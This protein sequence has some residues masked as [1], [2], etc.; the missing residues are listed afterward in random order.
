MVCVKIKAAGFTDPGQ[1]RESNQDS[2][3][4]H[5]LEPDIRSMGVFV[6]A[7]GVGGLSDGK[8]A[9]QKVVDAFREWSETILTD[10][11]VMVGK[12]ASDMFRADELL[13]WVRNEWVKLIDKVNLDIHSS[14][15]KRNTQS[16]T[17]LVAL[18]VA[19]SRY[20]VVHAGDSR[21]YRVDFFNLTPMTEDHT[22][23]VKSH[24]AG[25]MTDHEFLRFKGSDPLTMGVGTQAKCNA[26]FSEGKIHSKTMFFLCSDGVYKYIPKK[27]LHHILRRSRPNGLGRAL[28]TLR[29]TI[30][31]SGAGDNLTGILVRIG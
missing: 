1:T 27:K 25:L 15:M 7:D 3:Y 9:S 8:E 30:C 29:E 28:E 17:T 14:A 20:L 18:L 10:K 11:A 19:G 12:I 31:R 24:K 5:V 21:L 4:W 16:G 23:S 13:D 2:L 26:A 6:V 22:L